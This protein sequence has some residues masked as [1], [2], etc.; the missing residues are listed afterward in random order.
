MQNMNANRMGKK[1]KY[2]TNVKYDCEHNISINPTKITI[3]FK[4]NC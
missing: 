3:T 2:K 4:R 1:T